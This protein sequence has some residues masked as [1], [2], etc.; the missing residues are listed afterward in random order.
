MLAFLTLKSRVILV[1]LAIPLNSIHKTILTTYVY[2]I[3]T[4]YSSY[5]SPVRAE[6]H[7]AGSLASE[8]SI[9]F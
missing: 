4:L 3:S 6:Y 1:F 8:F 7:R 2:V 9:S 5:K